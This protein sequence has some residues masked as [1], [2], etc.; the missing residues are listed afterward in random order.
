M[1]L[2][3][4]YI[5]TAGGWGAKDITV[6]GGNWSTS[7]NDERTIWQK[8]GI[9]EDSIAVKIV[10]D[11]ALLAIVT[12]LQG[13][14]TGD[15]I[16]TW[17]FVPSKVK[18]TGRELL[19]IV[20]EI[21]EIN[22][23]GTSGVS[24]RAF[25]ESEILMRNYPERKYPVQIAE[26]SPKEY[27]YRIVLPDY[28]LQDLL[29]ALSQPDYAKYEYVF[30]YD[31]LPVNI[32]G[33]DDLS[34]NKLV[35]LITVL[36]PS[37][38][39]IQKYFG[40]G[41]I[42]VCLPGGKEFKEPISN[43][44]G[45]TI[46]LSVT[47]PNCEP[48]SVTGIVVDDEMEIEF[49]NGGRP[50]QWRR[51]VSFDKIR[52]IDSVK[53]HDIRMKE[54]EIKSSNYNKITNTLP[55]EEYLKVEVVIKANS[56]A[57][58]KKIIN[59]DQSYT[60]QME[61]IK[62]SKEYI[63]RKDGRELKIS[64]EGVID[65]P[66]KPIDGYEA[67]D[68]KCTTLKYIGATKSAKNNKFWNKWW[69][70]CII[71]FVL[72]VIL[73]A[74]VYELF[75]SDQTERQARTESTTQSQSQENNESEATGNEPGSSSSSD[76]QDNKFSKENAIKYLDNNNVWHRDSLEQYPLLKGL[77]D[78]LNEFKC[79]EIIERKENLMASE[80]YA[81][82]VNK[83]DQEIKHS[84]V[85]VPIGKKLNTGAELTITINKYIDYLKKV[86]STENQTDPGQGAGSGGVGFGGNR[87]KV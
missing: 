20:K 37:L 34:N 44:K 48:I 52:L 16:T 71:S 50:F 82:L 30:F 84:R 39:T 41:A 31:K 75:A 40:G 70:R 17:I 79:I 54:V 9:D 22:Q 29:G 81:N 25:E 85:R 35:N 62:N 14:R 63:Y 19:S 69:F 26:E 87:G 8:Y 27:A 78:E 46:N 55:E 4:R 28:S 67:T 72:G 3:Y 38:S 21:R 2:G 59:L 24:E 65:D 51:K 36:P 80:K 77:Y 49:S 53:G 12:P 74:C 15:N 47:K 13:S 58:V 7:I 10:K 64:I 1:K 68:N 42:K 6:N 73:C 11:G 57:P 66:Y 33:L 23:R 61:K 5:L 60:I 18:V 76:E 45:K 56:Y 43:S 83:I 32:N 86:N